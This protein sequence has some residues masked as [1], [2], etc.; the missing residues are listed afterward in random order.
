MILRFLY[1][2]WRKNN[3]ALVGDDFTNVNIVIALVIIL[4]ISSPVRNAFF[5]NWRSIEP[6][7]RK[8]F[9]MRLFKTAILLKTKITFDF[10]QT[11]LITYKHGFILHW[12]P[13]NRILMQK[14]TLFYFIL[15][16]LVYYLFIIFLIFKVK[17]GLTSPGTFG[18][19]PYIFRVATTFGLLKRFLYVGWLIITETS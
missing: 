15:F 14:M 13:S 11:I 1:R 2:I 9:V 6:T 3:Q 10:Y 5:R 7:M 12:F 16:F 8:C 19:V 18:I 17:S 4:F